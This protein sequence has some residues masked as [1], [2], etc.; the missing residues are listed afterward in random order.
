MKA[1]FDHLSNY[2][3]RKGPMASND[4]IGRYG[5]F[6]IPKIGSPLVFY[7]MATCG[8]HSGWDHVSVRVEH[9][10]D[11]RKGRCPT[12]D[13]MCFIKDLFW[14]PEECVIQYHPPKSD[15]VNNHPHVL[16]LWMPTDEK[17]P[18]PPSEL[19]GIK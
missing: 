2:R 18:R 17:I 11:P 14:E 7:C 8:E 12:W 3:V 10:S 9:S 5:F 1:S 4:A 6:L 15:Y 19:V 16:H 13:E